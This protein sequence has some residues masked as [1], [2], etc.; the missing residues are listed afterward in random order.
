MCRHV[1]EHLIDPASV[2]LDLLSLLS[3]GG[4]LVVSCPNGASKEGLFYP[5][6]WKKYLAPFARENG[7][8]KLH[9][10]MFSL[11]CKYG[12]GIDPPRHLW[13]ITRKGMN[14]LIVRDGRFSVSMKSASL[15]NSIYSPYWQRQGGLDRVRDLICVQ[16]CGS[17]CEGVHLI[18]EVRRKSTK[19][20]VE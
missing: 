19:P 14:A 3:V 2:I 16:I 5:D 4:V 9:A 12:W 13:A 17:L 8:S 7:L 15:V 11:S 6:Q 18:A 20:L 10:A 1:I